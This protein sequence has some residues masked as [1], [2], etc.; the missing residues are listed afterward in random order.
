MQTKVTE[1]LQKLDRLLSQIDD[2]AYVKPI[3]SS[4][5]ATIGKHTRHILEFF[6]CLLDQHE[7][8]IVNYDQRER[9]VRIESHVNDARELINE[10]ILGSE[11]IRGA[12]KRIVLETG[13]D[14][15]KQAMDTTIGRELW[16]NVEHAIHHMA[17]IKM[18]IS[19]E[20]PQLKLDD[21]FGVAYS[22][23]QYNKEVLSTG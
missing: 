2:A 19:Y 13:S 6:R 8:G 18:I 16:Y 7:T 22:T 15:E 4:G 21:D 12:N 3:R 17:I 5:D 11:K 1:T 23:V 10:I 14:P 9:D 20:H